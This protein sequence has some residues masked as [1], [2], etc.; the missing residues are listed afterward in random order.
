[1][2]SALPLWVLANDWGLCSQLSSHY[3]PGRETRSPEHPVAS[4]GLHRP[5]TDGTQVNLDLLI[6]ITV[7]TGEDLKHASRPSALPGQGGPTVCLPW[8]GVFQ[9]TARL[10]H[11]AY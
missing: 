10:S 2:L 11:T 6:G 5:G 4:S 8:S 3:P 9:S 7:R 1:M